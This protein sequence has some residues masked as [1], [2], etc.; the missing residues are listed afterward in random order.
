MSKF[1]YIAVFVS[2]IFSISVTHIMAGVIR[3]IYRGQFNTTHFVLTAFF[4]MV[5][6]LNW[7]TG[8]A[9]HDT[10]VWSFD[11]F[12]IIIVWAVSHYLGA[13][14]LY[15]PLSAGVEH[16]FQYRRNWF[17]WAF[18]GVSSADILQTAG[19]GGLFAPWYYLPYVLHYI[20]LAL[21]AIF[22]NKPGVHRWIAWYFLLSIVTWA[23]AVRRL[24][25]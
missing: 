22:V 14:T 12:L 15:P 6:L 7:W 2:I 8:Y 3:S 24:L 23:F 20:V 4:F 1:E 9:W 11:G 17:L 21:V 10:E 18:V 25:A 5:L 13:I 16:P 19:S